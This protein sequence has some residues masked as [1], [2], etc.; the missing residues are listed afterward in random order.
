M[1]LDNNIIE[2]KKNNNFHFYNEEVEQ[3]EKSNK[4]SVSNKLPF[5]C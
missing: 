5:L 4:I 1:Y 2:T 3:K